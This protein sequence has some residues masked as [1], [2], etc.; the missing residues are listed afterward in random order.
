MRKEQLIESVWPNIQELV[1]L[2][3]QRKWC[4][5]AELFAK[6]ILVIAGTMFLWYARQAK[7]IS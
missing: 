3:Y 2:Y 1:R 5:I 7:C 6:G 4:K